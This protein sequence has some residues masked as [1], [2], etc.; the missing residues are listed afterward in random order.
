MYINRDFNAPLQLKCM[1]S[2]LSILA[3][4]TVLSDILM[5]FHWS[6]GWRAEFLI[7]FETWA[8]LAQKWLVCAPL[9]LHLEP[10]N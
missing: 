8:K 2:R 7:S 10:I 6:I 3:I 9:G 5:I 1:G 4:T